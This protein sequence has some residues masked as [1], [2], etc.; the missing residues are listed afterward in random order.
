M[1]KCKNNNIKYYLAR[2][3]VAVFFYVFLVALACACAGVST[4]LYANFLSHVTAGKFELAIRFLIFAG[5]STVVKRISWW[6]NFNIYYKYS[7]I[8]WKEIAIDLTR[9]SF[10][11]S[12]ATFSDYNSGTFV[13][14]IMHDPN[15]LLQNLSSIIEVI[16]ETLTSAVVIVYMI[17]LNWIIGLVYIGVLAIAFVIE[18][19]RRRARK[20]NKLRTKK[21]NDKTYS[22][23]TEIV[24]SE[25][26]IKAL[27]LEEKLHEISSESFEQCQLAKKHADVVDTNFY[28]SRCV[29]IEV[30]GIFILFLGMYLMKI[31]MLTLAAF[32]LIYSYRDN[33]YMLAWNVGTIFKSVTEVSVCN[34]RMFSLY[35][36]DLYPTEV[37]GTKN[38]K[39]YKGQIDFKHVKFSYAE[40]QTDDDE[41]INYSKKNKIKIKREK[42]KCVFKDLTFTVKPNTTVAFVGKSGS[43]KSTILSLISKLIDTDEGKV[44]IDGTDIKNI[45]KESLRQNISLINQFPYIFDMTIRENLL[46]VKKEA[47]EEE[48]WEVLK[49][50][51]FYDDVKDMPKGLD[52]KVGET[53]VKLSGGQRQRL[54]IARAL[55]KESKIILF[56]ESTSSLDNFAQSKIQESIEN[57]KGQ[58]TIVIVAHRLS[59][60]KNV[61]TIY[62]LDKGQITASG[63]FE[64]LFN[65]SEKFK[66]MFLTENLK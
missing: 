14:R 30:F 51:S 41:P 56:D 53:G 46:L 10:K 8:I 9:R 19:N 31:E 37:F 60:I 45:S 29:V 12:T 4:I 34:A 40:R 47:T 43:G 38:K 2:H 17:C 42:T 15:E 50:A 64:E 6:G 63:T 20:R 49:R 28:S 35:D 48:L 36:E 54:A 33:M 22:L 27:G 65:N 44:A 61:D 1:E 13:Q 18:I 26:D 3:K 57:L 62:F 58:H 21:V 11:F 39:K 66:E 16:S 32:I 7:N 52:T 25:K 5:T 24:K 59:T 55:L 23:V